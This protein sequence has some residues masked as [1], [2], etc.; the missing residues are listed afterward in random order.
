MSSQATNNPSRRTKPTKKDKQNA[1]LEKRFGTL[2][3]G[4]FATRLKKLG[5]EASRTTPE[6]MYLFLNPTQVARTAE[7]KYGRPAY[8][9]ETFRNA[10]VLL[11]LTITWMSLGLAGAA[12]TENISVH[13]DLS[14][15]S[16][17]QQWGEGF[18]TLGTATIGPLR[19]PLL[20]Q[21]QPW[22]TF[23]H[24]AL[25]DA[26]LLLLLLLL[27][28]LF[29]LFEWRAQARA[30]QLSAWTEE[31]L[32]HFSELSLH[33]W[34]KTPEDTQRALADKMSEAMAKLEKAL[35]EVKKVMQKDVIESVSKF[36]D[37]IIYQGGAVDRYIEGAKEVEG[38]VVKLTELYGKSEDVYEKLGD[39]LPEMGRQVAGLATHQSKSADQIEQ[40]ARDIQAAAREMK[41]AAIYIQGGSLPSGAFAGSGT[42]GGST[43]SRWWDV[44]RLF[45]R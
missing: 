30:T 10:L 1:R 26:A 28:L 38:Y 36:N 2:Q 7:R 29:H 9:V 24:V 21:A 20:W 37:A 12:Y 43:A 14:T 34:G 45:R 32:Y 5:A 39:T 8:M 16:F 44:R 18:G 4:E 22:F 27:T 6:E 3:N 35:E 13:K 31:T 25:V 17:L 41:E 23:A 15:E 33:R 42:R 40:A 19:I 11:P